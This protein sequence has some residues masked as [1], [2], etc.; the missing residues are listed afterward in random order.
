[1]TSHA[2][3]VY[4]N[5]LRSD[6]IDVSL[7][8]PAPLH[9]EDIA[10]G[11]RADVWDSKHRR[12]YQLCA[13]SGNPRGINGYGIGTPRKIVPV[14]A[15][16]EGWTEPVTTAPPGQF[17][18]VNLPETMLRWDGWSLVASRPG[19]HLPDTG[20]NSLESDTGN[21][22]PASA[23][24]QVQI[25]YAATPGTLPVLRFGRGYRFRARVVDLAG[26]SVPFDATAPFAFTTPETVYGRLEPVPSPVIVPCA[27]RT[28][29]ESLETLVIRSNYDVPD[30]AVAACERHLAPPVTSVEL[31]AAHGVLD[32]A[33]GVPD[34]AL[35]ST[36]AGR[37]GLSYRSASVLSKYTARSKPRLRTNGCTTPQVRPAS[38]CLTCP[39]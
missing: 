15:G 23:N 31:A 25:D 34:K 22:P 36:L 24:F 37:D 14:P 21:P 5:W 10:Q 12:W 35:Y 32:D 16:D 1:M 39:T 6:A 27:P 11:Y 28:P 17:G 8:T 29:G 13:R 20:A 18:P 30:S 3:A 19:K 2:E 33:A 4:G 9:A 38:P 26:N 7:P